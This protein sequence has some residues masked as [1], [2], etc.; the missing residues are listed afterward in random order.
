MSSRSCVDSS[1][2][3][4]PRRGSS[5]TSPSVA[6]TFKASR[7]GVREMPSSPAS[8][9][10]SIHSPLLSARAW[11]MARSRSATSSPAGGKVNPLP[12]RDYPNKILGARAL[13]MQHAVHGVTG[14]R[15][16]PATRG[17]AVLGFHDLGAFQQFRRGDRQAGARKGQHD[18]VAR[19]DFRQQHHAVI[20]RLG[21]VVDVLAEA[22]VAAKQS[23]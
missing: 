2:T 19:V 6:S 14:Q 22:V 13:E 12:P 18:L 8:R 17:Q 9:I 16:R 10:S 3:K 21:Q 11:I 15:P 7:R 20:A 1:L 5:R 23:R 4:H